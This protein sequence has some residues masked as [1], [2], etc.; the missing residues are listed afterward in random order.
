MAPE[1]PKTGP[2][3]IFDHPTEGIVESLRQRIARI[4]RST[5][6]RADGNPVP[7]GCG[8]LDRILPEGGFRRGTLVEWLCPSEGSGTVTLALHAAAEACRQGGTVVVLDRA[9]EFYPPAAAR[10]GIDLEQM[11]VVQAAGEADN[12]W[13][14]DQCLRC[15]GVAAVV[16]W[17]EGLDGRTF[18][19]LQLAAEEGGGL[20][21][22]V[23][24]HEVR[25]EPSWADVR[26]L[27]EPQPTRSRTRRR[28]RIHLVRCHGTTGG[29]CVDVEFDDETRDVHPAPRLAHPAAPRRAAGA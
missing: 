20:G 25:G 14:L 13:A 6:G 26:L 21:L 27:V 10:L 15:P 23:R 3:L 7:S 2:E 17:P 16:A 1:Q 9:R 8:P 19:R 4:E 24:P 18:R 11:I 28:L 29:R 22:L 12:A 5:H